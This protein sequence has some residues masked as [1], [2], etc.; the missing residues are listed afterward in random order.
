MIYILILTHN[1]LAEV[2]RCFESLAP[3][4]ARRDVRC[5]VLDNGSTDGT[6]QWLAEYNELPQEDR[7]WSHSNLGVAGGRDHLLSR[8]SPSSNDL[9]VFLDSD[10]VI[11]DDNW[12]DVLAN[13]VG[14]EA[15][16][17]A[18]PFGSF[19]LPD[20]SGFTAGIPGLVDTVA[21]ACQCWKAELFLQGLTIDVDTF[22]KFW[23]EDADACLQARNMGYD[24]VCTP[25]GVHHYPAQSG[26]GQDM[27]LHD[28]NFA[29]L[30]QKW[31]GKELVRIEGGY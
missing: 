14:D 2:Q 27:K 11:V 24:V 12:L 25:V 6:S 15:V 17:V 22:G 7:W 1:R 10:T 5:V 29:K 19:V 4:L 20:W 23:H 8:I 16:G 30:R 28:D 13:A 31:Q 18:G 21:G 26:F 3:T 9:I